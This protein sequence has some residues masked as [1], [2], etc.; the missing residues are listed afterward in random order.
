MTPATAPRQ[1]EVEFP[2]KLEFLFEPHRYKIAY[3]G[4]YG[5][6]SWSF[7]RALLL[8]GLDPSILWPGRRAGVRILCARETQRSIQESVHHL[9]ESQIDRM[10][11]NSKYVVQ[12]TSITAANG[13]EFAFAG[14]RQNVANIK[15]YEDFDIAW[16]SEA[17]GVTKNSWRVLIPTIRKEGS[18]IWADFNPELETDETYQ[19]FVVHPP[20]NAKVVHTT[21][22]DNPWLSKVIVEEMRQLKERDE[23]EYNHVYGGLCR[24]TVDGAIYARE[25][26]AAD[27]EFR[28]TRVPYDPKFPVHTFWD[29]G[30]GDNTSIWFAQ[31]LPFE[32]RLIDHVSGSLQALGHYVKLLKERPYAYGNHF[33]PHDAKAHELGTG[34]TIE[35][36]LK[37]QM[38]IDRVKVCKRVGMKADGINAVRQVFGRCWFDKEKCADGI[39][40]L[41]HYRY[42]KDENLGTFRREPLHDWASHD[43]DSFQTFALSIKELQ[44]PK[45]KEDEE[46]R[47]S[48]MR[49]T[50]GGWMA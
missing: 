46:P 31:S 8:I 17:A 29:L 15:S 47:G 37:E 20:D 1:I 9:L 50:D 10:S 24:T 28:I 30:Y 11:L 5:V 35:E 42:E 40:S 36:Q 34:R 16:V 14:I 49:P 18:E 45:P 23:P 26:A 6:K 44:R 39:Q 3:G 7:A 41:R 19:R 12:N 13:T 4:R 22:K 32:F 43:A 27:S 25:M 2:E 38:G 48:G 21:W 33:L